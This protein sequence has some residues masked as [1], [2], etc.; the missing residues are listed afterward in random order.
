MRKSLFH[1]MPFRLYFS[2]PVLILCL[3]QAHFIKGQTDPLNLSDSL[4]VLT[5]RYTNLPVI[6]IFNRLETECGLR[7]FF[8]EDWFAGDTA[9]LNV[10]GVHATEAIQR[11][12]RGKPYEYRVIMNRYFVFLPRQEVDRLM[13]ELNFTG[14]QLSEDQFIPIGSSDR[15]GRQKLTGLSGTVSDGKTGEPL[16]GATIQVDNLPQGAVSLPDGTYKLTLSPGIHTLSVS[17]VGYERALFY[18]KM[19]S[20]G[21]L[22]LEIFDKSV[23][24]ED[25]IIYGQRFDK[26]VS[27]QQMSLVELDS[28]SIGQLP[29][30][31]G[32]RDILKGLTTLA[33]IKSS[34]EFS[35]GI[36]VRGGGED[37]NLYL[38]NGAPLFN[39]SH[40]FGLFSV[41]NPDVVDRLTL[42]KGHIPAS[43]GERVSSV[44]DI[45]TRDLPPDK[46]RVRG[47]VGL[48]DGRLMA[49][50]PLFDKK[51]FIV[52]GGR[53]NY[54]NWLLNQLNDY[55]L[56]NSKASFHDL[57]ATLQTRIGKSRLTLS[58]YSSADDFRFS[59][60]VRYAYRNNL[61]ALNW[62][63]LIGPSMASH[64]TISYSSYKVDKDDIAADLWKN[65]I[66]SGIDYAA[67]KYRIQYDG[68]RHHLETGFGFIRY[69]VSRGKQIPIT[70][71]SLMPAREVD[72]EQGYEGSYFINDAISITK[73]I[74]VQAGVRYSFF[75]YT[76]PHQVAQYM[77]GMPFDTA[78]IESVDQYSRGELIQTWHGPEPRLS[79]FYRLSDES[80][81]KLSYNR[82]RQYLYLLSSS[83]VATPADVWKLADS[84]LK[85]VV[86]DQAAIGYYRNFL[87]NSLEASVEVYYKH[88]S[89]IPEVKGGDELEM[90]PFPETRLVPV[91]GRNYGVEATFRKNS[92]KLTGWIIYTYSRSLRKSGTVHPADQINRNNWYP[93]S[94]DKPNDV[95]LLINYNLN[96]RIRFSA[97]FAYSTGRPVTL[98]EY[99]YLT[100]GETIV[101]FSDRNRY[102]IPDYHRLDLS[103]SLD[104]SLKLRKR[105]KGSWTFSVLN[106]YGRKNPFTVFYKK[107]EPSPVNDYKTF[108]LYTLYLIGRPIPALTYTFVF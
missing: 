6:E 70:D 107:E 5:V 50:A 103:M 2:L 65:R 59:T 93:S 92:G 32:D 25:I 4:P 41:V 39:T 1:S 55:D 40:V 99:K 22:N 28:R 24:I 87:N 13:G 51:A 19:I 37:Q 10:T 23:A 8:R 30:V 27:S 83:N 45:R 85:P 100:N 108:S 74:S 52:I 95:S 3:C 106:V 101:Y 16:A 63:Y 35:S 67:V 82:N 47:G 46:F 76:G 72:D 14:R 94:Y 17:S 61:A 86:A 53:K 36:N 97:S 73:N 98:P 54:S 80:S 62:N 57:N 71:D 79:I 64:L 58:G 69:Q 56:S 104:Q 78:F 26:N 90:N 48:Y 21:N 20:S 102:R 38:I 68:Q 105:L 43:F 66:K 34:G 18:V 60:N 33:G 42:Y 91:T 84:H 29:S 9:S 15:A 89:S 49:E 7:F 96:R 31:T 44:V 77:P 75:A 81:V 12:L 11:L 88:L